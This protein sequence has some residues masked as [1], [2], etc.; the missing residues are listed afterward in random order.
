[1]NSKF[2]VIEGLEGAGKTTAR[3]IVVETLRSHGVKDVVFTREP[4]GTP[5]AEKLRELIKQGIADEKVTDKAEV[6]MLYAA[7]VQLVDNVI[8]PALANGNWVIGDRHDLS[9]QAYQGGGRGIDQQLLRS[10]RDTVLGDFRPDLTLY[11]D[12]PPAI[13]LQRARQRGELDRIEQESL[14]FFDRTRSRYQEL[15]AEDD[16]ILTI[17]ASQPIDAVSAD[18]QATLQQWLQQQ[19][20]QPVA[21]GLG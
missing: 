3:N 1:M 11:L 4:G 21:Q 17:D 12:L 20:L 6:L 15:A 9:S 5:L 19:G 16:S 7:R 14:A 13:G 10:L 8:K 18:I 2:I